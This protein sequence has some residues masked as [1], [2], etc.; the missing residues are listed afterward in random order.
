MKVSREVSPAL[1]A[2]LSAV[3]AIV[4]TT[5][6]I[7][8][9]VARAPATF[10]LPAASVKAPASI[11][12][13]PVPTSPAVGVNV[14][15]YVAPVPAKFV[16]IPPVTIRS[17]AVKVVDD[18]LSLKVIV[19]VVPALSVCRLLVMTTVGG[20][21]SMASVGESAPARFVFPATSVNL[22]AATVTVPVPTKLAVGVNVAV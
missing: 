5:M 13:V 6:S 8:S 20:F 14:A 18:S 22:P 2:V 17:A 3:T 1:S 10:G 7:L 19:A 21:V 9:G 12:T 16:T 11:A 15:V 4:G